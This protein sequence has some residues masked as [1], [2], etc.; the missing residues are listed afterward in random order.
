MH[1]LEE[2]DQVGA[3]GEVAVVEHEARWLSLMTNI[4][5]VLVEVIDPGGV[6]CEAGRRL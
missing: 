3:V 6:V 4:V 5:R 1:V 2:P